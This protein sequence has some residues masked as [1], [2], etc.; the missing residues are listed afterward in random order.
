[1][2]SWVLLTETVDEGAV[3]VVAVFF[4]AGG[5][6]GGQRADEGVKGPAGGGLGGGGVPV[7]GILFAPGAEADVGCGDVGGGSLRLG[8]DIGAVKGGDL[9]RGWFAGEFEGGA[10]IKAAVEGPGF[11]EPVEAGG[12]GGR[13]P[14]EGFVAGAGQELGAEGDGAG[15]RGVWGDGAVGGEDTDCEA[16]GVGGEAAGG[17]FDFGAPRHWVD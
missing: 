13:L 8:G 1:M 2:V 14:G 16:A 17:G 15:D 5:G 11:E 10:T 4:A 7:V 6:V 12:M 9:R 3:A